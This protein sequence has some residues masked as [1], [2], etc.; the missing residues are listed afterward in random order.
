MSDFIDDEMV[1]VV[2]NLLSADYYRTRVALEAALP[3]IGAKLAN[4]LKEQR[5]GVSNDT[6]DKTLEIAAARIRK[7]TG[8]KP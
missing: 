5:C 6:Y 1:E 2:S 8:A 7:L 3:L 4:D